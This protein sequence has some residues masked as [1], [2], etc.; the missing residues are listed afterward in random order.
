MNRL[1]NDLRYGVRML[2]KTPTAAVTVPL[3]LSLG[4]GL[5]ALTFSLINGG[6]LA[7][8][9]FEGGDRVMRIGR[10]EGMTGADYAMLSARQRSFDH[11][12]AI[13]MTTVTLAVEG[14]STEP[15]SSASIT[16][17][18]L[19]LASAQPA[20]GRPFTDADVARDAP[21]VVIVSHAVWRDRLAS[22]PG[23]LGRTV[24]V[25]GRPSQVVG[26]MPEGFLFPW[27]QQLWTPLR[28]DP[29]GREHGDWAVVGRLRPG[30]SKEVAMRELAA[31]SSELDRKTGEAGVE[32]SL[33]M[34]GFTELLPPGQSAVLAALML[35]IALMVL[36]VACANVANVLLARAVDRRREVALR[37]ALG[38]SRVRIIAQLLTEI[39]LLAALGAAGGVVIAMVGVRFVEGVMPPTGMPYWIKMR[40]DLPVLG[41]V[42]IVAMLAVLMAGLMP[43]LQASRANPHELLKDISRG[44]SSFRLGRVMRRL[45]G[46]EVAL[47]FVLLVMAGLFVKSALNF[48]RTD[49][50]FEP[51]DVYTAYMRFP[52]T[53]Y[54]DVESLVRFAE[55]LS[56]RLGSL[57]QVEAVALASAVPGVGSPPVIA[58][59]PEGAP[60][61]DP[62]E[63][64]GVGT[65]SVVVTPGFF[66][67][68]RT[69][70]AGRNFDARDRTGALPVA[71]VNDA[72]AKRYF[73]GGALDRRIRFVGQDGAQE[74]RTIIGVTP[75]LMVGGVKGVRQE[76]VYL[77]LA[78]NQPDELMVVARSQGRVAALTAPVR[79]SLAAL[80]SDVA[81]FQVRPLDVVIAQANS[82]YTW[83]SLLFLISGG[84]ALFLAA[85]GLYGVMAFWVVQRTRE[86]GVRMALG[87]QARDIR[88]LVLRQGMTQMSIGLLAGVLLA[89]PAARL[90]RVALYGVVP[91]D[92]MV[93]GSIL[94]VLL[95]AAWLGCWLPARRATRLSPL[96]ALIAE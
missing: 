17:S 56:E 57:P 13:S 6:V 35:G 66:A 58:V 81:L 65:R 22:D 3:V 39:S 93:F 51:E 70:V 86:I 78:Q 11:I 52:E 36:L 25:N 1:L 32:S 76:A 8:L 62:D 80:D 89:L 75:N 30:V 2:M 5:S 71:I 64:E 95:G 73:P 45:I 37:L 83:L 61:S 49:F 18:V 63:E 67:L 44:S 27:N 12:G 47:S 15:V 38:A 20:M 85:I 82:E 24:R 23:V 26:V 53:K 72:F 84:V 50:A 21:A 92:P 43:A 14:A 48:R 19:P 68:F 87:G 96:H 60:V 29:V 46:V 74:W 7:S 34:M 9:P 54:G 69:T 4:I 55:A 88:R 10:E 59:E 16:P 77:P 33:G 79:E 91:Y 31:I 94:A 40:I 41:F 90:V 42:A 28:V